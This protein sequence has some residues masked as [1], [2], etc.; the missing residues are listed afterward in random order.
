MKLN[1]TNTRKYLKNAGFEFLEFQSLRDIR[2]FSAVIKTPDN[3]IFIKQGGVKNVADALSM[4]NEFFFYKNLKKKVPSPNYHL[5]DEKDG[6]II[7]E[8]LKGY[9]HFN[10]KDYLHSREIGKHIASVHNISNEDAQPCTNINLNNY[11]YFFPKV[12]PEMISNGGRLFS[13][14][15]QLCQK[16]T[17]LNQ[18]IQQLK[19]EYTYDCF[20]HG[21]LKFDNILVKSTRTSFDCRFI[22]WE[23]CSIGDRYFDIGYVTGNMLFMWINKI[24]F[25][26]NF[27]DLNEPFL[28]NVKTH[29]RFFLDGYLKHLTTVIDLDKLKLARYT[30]LFLS[31]MFYS[32]TLFGREYTKHDILKLQIARNLLVAPQ[33]YSTLLFN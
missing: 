17:D 13:K 11:F 27:M 33:S 29:I 28:N 2:N 7:T 8:Y 21:D 22:D 15:V 12:T 10:L 26:R 31:N 25:R 16:Y 6:I 23:L 3:N 19:D 5:I 32:A 18:A 9:T 14:Y 20:V 24:R 1:P 4:E 30:G